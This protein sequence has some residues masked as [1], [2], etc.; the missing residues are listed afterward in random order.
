MNYN[1]VMTFCIEECIRQEDSDNVSVLSM[2]RAY[3]MAVKMKTFDILFTTRSIEYL[4]NE[5]KHSNMG[6]RV[7]PV[8][9]QNGE[10]GIRYS[11]IS[12]SIENL[13]QA[14]ETL[15]PEEWYFEFEKIHPFNDGNGRTGAI[16]YNILAGTINNPIV[17][18]NMFN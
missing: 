14:K 16:L 11:L 17:P 18:P 5:V 4:G 3:R 12:R 15:T 8:T 1:K 10:K 6:F 2:F 7:T 9:F 13:C